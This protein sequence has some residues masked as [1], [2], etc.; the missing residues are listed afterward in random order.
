MPKQNSRKKSKQTVIKQPPIAVLIGIGI[1]AV[2]V[3]FAL[4]Q[5]GRPSVPAGAVLDLGVMG[6]AE[7]GL[8]SDGLPYLGN[9]NASIVIV[10]YE[11]FGCHNCK[12]FAESIEPSLVE[13]YVIDGSV[14]LINHPVAFVNQQSKPAAEAAECAL[15]L[16]RFWEYRHLLFQNQGVVPFS[17]D[18]L[19]NFATQA[20]MNS[21]EFSNCYDQKLYEGVVID[22]TLDAQR[23]GVTGTP[24]FEIN[25]AL[26]TG[27]TPIDSSNPDRPGFKQI[28]AAIQTGEQ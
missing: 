16:D 11:D 6:Q 26:Y 19:V 5:I 3:V 20:G 28:I 22:R 21:A 27:V 8:T 10:Q 23:R 12:T 7:S 1:I 4:I 14:L 17:R 25:G 15:K 9:P 13:Q 18:N 24:T 2:I